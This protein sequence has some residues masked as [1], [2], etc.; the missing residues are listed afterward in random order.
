MTRA[1]LTPRPRSQAAFAIMVALSCLAAASRANPS[2]S[3]SM[4]LRIWYRT[5]ASTASPHGSTWVTAAGSLY[6]WPSASMSYHSAA[7]S[8]AASAYAIATGSRTAFTCSRTSATPMP[9]SSPA[10]TAARTA[11]TADD[12]ARKHIPSTDLL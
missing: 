9:D 1:N 6:P 7:S 8:E 10:R 2:A 5:V 11:R 3:P 12:S 4:S